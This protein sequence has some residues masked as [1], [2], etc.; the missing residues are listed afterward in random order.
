MNPPELQKSNEIPETPIQKVLVHKSWQILP[1]KPP[2]T[3]VVAFVFQAISYKSLS[4]DVL[5]AQEQSLALA[6]VGSWNSRSGVFEI[7]D[8]D[9]CS[10]EVQSLFSLDLLIQ[11]YGY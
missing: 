1:V 9:N 4:S 2:L 11:G 5:K 10:W 7:Q 3:L 6:Q 8:P